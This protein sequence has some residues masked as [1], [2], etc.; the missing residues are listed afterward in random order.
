[1]SQ[2]DQ[3]AM[4]WYEIAV[5]GDAGVW[6]TLLA[7]LEASSGQRAVR[8][9]EVPLRPESQGERLHGLLHAGSH[10]AAFAPGELA[11]GLTAALATLATPAT[12]AERA[13]PADVD[14]PAAAGAGLRLEQVR[15]V[16]GGHFD[17]S[18]EVFAEPIARQIRAVLAAPPPGVEVH[19]SRDEEERAAEGGVP[20]SVELYAPL[21]CYA[22]RAWGTVTGPF[23]GILEM[24]RRLHSLPFV[25]ER[26]LELAT[27]RVNPADFAPLACYAVQER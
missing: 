12:L 9:P 27:H 3:R 20:G 1:M 2:A 25:Y 10:H 13:A 26:Q 23:P 4:S 16:E 6:E 15:K 18:V 22:Y 21:H 11:R 7:K 5:E 17:F 14:A 24:H 8:R 19:A